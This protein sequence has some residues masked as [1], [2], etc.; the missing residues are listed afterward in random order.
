MSEWSG[1]QFPSKPSRWNRCKWKCQSV[2]W[3]G[4]IQH[5]THRTQNRFHKKS[6]NCTHNKQAPIPSQ[7]A[8]ETSMT[9]S[10]CVCIVSSQQW[11][12]HIF[13]LEAAVSTQVSVYMVNVP[14][15]QWDKK[16]RCVWKVT[17]AALALLILCWKGGILQKDTWTNYKHLI[18]SEQ[19]ELFTAIINCNLIKLCLRQ[20]LKGHCCCQVCII[21]A[22]E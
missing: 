15:R 6:K 18:F 17:G 5:I 22:H 8:K 12:A 19:L 11:F 1:Y 4:L 10:M 14:H 20:K 9:L 13:G 2:T 21:L 3:N 16:Y 7:T